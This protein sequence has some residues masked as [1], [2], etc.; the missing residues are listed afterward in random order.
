[1]SV[2]KNDNSV[3]FE[4]ALQSIYDKQT[5]KPNQVVLVLDGPVPNE[6]NVIIENFTNRNPG[7]LTLVP[8]KK[9][10]GLGEALRVGTTH[11]EYPII[12]RM[13]SDDISDGERFEKQISYMRSHPDIDVLGSNILEFKNDVNE[14][15]L[16]IREVP[17]SMNQITLFSKRRNPMNH[18]TVCMR[19]SAIEKSGGYETCLLLEDYYLWLKMIANGCKLENINEPLVFVRVGNGFISKRS[20]KTRIKGWKKLQVYMLDNHMVNRFE[21]M[22][23]MLYICAFVFT[24]NVIKGPLYKKFLRK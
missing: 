2:Y 15:F 23:N 10:V 22:L 9:N 1:M 7:I 16:M 5:L 11:C 17:Q 13:D 6:I 3:F 21:A 18:V 24:P 19:K 14:D 8:L 20:S 12:C 4:M